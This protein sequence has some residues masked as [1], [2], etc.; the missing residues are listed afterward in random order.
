[1]TII[2]L[3]LWALLT[4]PLSGAPCDDALASALSARL[5]AACATSEEATM[6]E[7]IEL[8][9]IKRPA[10]PL[11]PR[12]PL[13]EIDAEGLRLEGRALSAAGLRVALAAARSSGAPIKALW[14]AVTPEAP[15][16]AVA[17][18]LSGA[19]LEGVERARLLF[20]ATP[21]PAARPA[22]LAGLKALLAQNPDPAQ[23]A[24]WLA[25]QISQI[26]RGCEG[27]EATFAALA[28]A[29]P[30]RRCAILSEGFGPGYVACGC[31]PNLDALL[32]YFDLIYERRALTYVEITLGDDARTRRW[33]KGARWR[34]VA[35]EI[36]GLD[37]QAARLEVWVEAL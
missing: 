17:E 8:A 14:I 22:R 27:V 2:T 35:E 9:R 19:R 33:S 37:G 13:L 36:G 12:T 30:A 10:R 7:G 31:A 3:S 15:I 21:D 6:P 28:S 29:A 26:I 16:E 11:G 23:R 32:T 1:M 5:Q 25:D 4:P 24:A 20:E 34:A 18:A